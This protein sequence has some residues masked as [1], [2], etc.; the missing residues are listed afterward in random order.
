MKKILSVLLLAA[1]AIAMASCGSGAETTTA[2]TT[3]AAPTTTVG[4]TT[5]PAITED[6]N[7]PTVNEE[8]ETPYIRDNADTTKELATLLDGKTCANDKIDRESLA[9][10]NFSTW[11]AEKENLPQMFDGVKTA[12]DWAAAG[13][14]GKIGGGCG[15]G[16]WFMWATTEKVKVS[17]YVITTGND[18]SKYP[19]RNPVAWNLYATNDAT[20]IQAAVDA[21][22]FN[23]EGWTNLDYVY[24]GTMTEADFTEN[25]YAVDADKQGEYQ[26]YCWYIEY[27]RDNVFQACE[28]EIFV[29]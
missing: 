25:G 15:G 3:T 26:Y 19:G 23:P 7:A 2:A 4:Q 28:F 16:A 20:A 10:L 5:P 29:G 12:D 18:N 13:D 22:E 24:D 17:A 9:S 11:N 14:Q 1:M 21:G 8:P 27:T 6:P